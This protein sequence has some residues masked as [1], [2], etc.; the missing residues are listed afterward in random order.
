MPGA[1]GVAMSAC[2][3]AGSSRGAVPIVL[4]GLGCR[5][6][7]GCLDGLH[8]LELLGVAAFPTCPRGM[9]QISL[10]PIWLGNFLV[11]GSLCNNIPGSKNH[12]FQARMPA[13]SLSA[14]KQSRAPAI[15]TADGLG[16]GAGC[17]LCGQVGQGHLHVQLARWHRSLV[18][19]HVSGYVTG[20]VA[21]AALVAA[22]AAAAAASAGATSAMAAG[23]S[24][25][26]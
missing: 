9:Q 2:R 25:A 18:G 26:V 7:K 23:S 20:A 15:G 13:T 3:A 12:S 19:C 24:A 6:R 22:A 21:G 4:S 16:W 1:S 8:P 11:P 10:V 17:L 14:A 5:R